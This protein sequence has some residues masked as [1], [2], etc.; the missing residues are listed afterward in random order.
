VTLRKKILAL[1]CSTSLVLSGCATHYLVDP[2]AAPNQEVRYDRGTP[3]T[4][5]E[6]TNGAVQITPFGIDGRDGRLVFGVAAYN[7]SQAP[8][9]FGVEDVY[10]TASGERQLH[11]F[12]SDELVR[13]ATSRAN[14]AT[15]AV[16]IL[17][18]AA[19]IS[20]ADGATTTTRGR[21][22]TRNG[23]V[24]FVSRTH[25]PGAAF[26][27]A[28]T[29]AI[30]T[31]LVIGSIRNDLD[32]TIAGISN[33]ILETTTIDPDRSYGGIVV[34]ERLPQPTAPQDV[35][36]TVNFNGEQHQFRY[37]IVRAR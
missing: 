7:K 18:L 25:D 14:A 22:W 16:A 3:T 34:G 26:V 19:A 20:A 32:R 31:G 36:V 27:G 28:A 24:R 13:E 29:A 11:V 5:S 8:S 23:P 37:S 12:T 21:F 4:Y 35:L 1:A 15:V 6:Q 2:V 33:E 17:G 10:M 9:N 30:G